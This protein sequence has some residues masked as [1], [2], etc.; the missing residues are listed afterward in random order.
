MPAKTFAATGIVPAEGRKN[1]KVRVRDLNTNFCH[2]L[3]RNCKIPHKYQVCGMYVCMHVEA[4]VE[5]EIGRRENEEERR[6][7]N[8]GRNN[9]KKRTATEK[10]NGRKGRRGIKSEKK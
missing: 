4:E 7:K 1:M 9:R 10:A 3:F 6:E 5:Q 2:S 8:R